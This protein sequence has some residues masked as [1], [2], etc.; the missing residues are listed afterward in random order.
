LD[1][2]PYHEP[3]QVGL[4][5]ALIND[6]QLSAA[7][8]EMARLSPRDEEAR[9]ILRVSRAFVLEAR[10][11][12]AEAADLYRALV[13]EDS[14][15]GVEARITALVRLTYMSERFGIAMNVPYSLENAPYDVRPFYLFPGYHER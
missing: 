5:V 15:F 4:V 8:A 1:D 9:Q 2:A 6:K 13:N 3:A 14:P 7:E 12:T 10:G 11:R